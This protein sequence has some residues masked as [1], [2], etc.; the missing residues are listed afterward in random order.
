LRKC[1]FKVRVDALLRELL[2]VSGDTPTLPQPFARQTTGQLGDGR[3][4]LAEALDKPATPPMKTRN[5]DQA[6]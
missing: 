5:E 4:D 2:M 1:R 3:A 6:F